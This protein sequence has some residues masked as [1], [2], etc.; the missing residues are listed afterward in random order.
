MIRK[1]QAWWLSD[2]DVREQ[3]QFIDPLFDLAA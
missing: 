3:N 1:G 2:D